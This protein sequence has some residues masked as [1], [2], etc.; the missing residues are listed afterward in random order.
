MRVTWG[1]L[2][3]ADGRGT[4]R[5]RQTSGAEVRGQSGRDEQGALECTQACQYSL[6]RSILGCNLCDSTPLLCT[7]S[8]GTHPDGPRRVSEV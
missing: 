3:R 4:R 2:H 8:S 7:T 6:M 5:G 1:G